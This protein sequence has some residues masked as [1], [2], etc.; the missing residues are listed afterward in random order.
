MGREKLAELTAKERRE[1]VLAFILRYQAEHN[2]E[3]PSQRT[4]Y[5]SLGMAQW[6]VSRCIKK[7]ERAGE[8]SRP[9]Y[10]APKA[11]AAGA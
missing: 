5:L 1:L 9:G 4:V 2:G 10:V 8:L 3:P 6:Q 7:L 11:K